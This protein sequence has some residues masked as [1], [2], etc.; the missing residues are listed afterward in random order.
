VIATIVKKALQRYWRQTRAL[1][2]DAKAILLDSGNNVLLVRGAD[3]TAWDLPSAKVKDGETVEDAVRR[4]LRS[5]LTLTLETAPSFIGLDPN[6]AGRA[7][8]VA[9]VA[10]RQGNPE[11]PLRANHSLEARRFHVTALPAALSPGVAAWISRV[12]TPTE[13]RG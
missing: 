13:G 8:H 9:I 7:G 5:D 6:P 12:P 11:A 1:S 2:L 3:G 10:V 4:M